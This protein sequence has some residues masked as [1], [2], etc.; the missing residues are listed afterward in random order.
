MEVLV[1]AIIIVL[2]FVI[3]VF[4][5]ASLED[6]DIED[7]LSFVATVFLAVIVGVLF[8]FLVLDISS[9]FL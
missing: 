9:L 3:G 6:I 7:L 2:I 8:F 4:V 1:T 5:G